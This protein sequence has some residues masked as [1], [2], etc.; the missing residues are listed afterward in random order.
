[1]SNKLHYLFSHLD[2][3]PENLSDLSKEQGERFH[4]DIKMMEE[5]Y[6]GRWDA[7]MM[8]DYWWALIRDCIKQSYRR[9]SYKKTFLQMN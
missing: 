7:H 2:Y 6:Q 4:Q 5:R 8:S 1:M 9:K 3:F